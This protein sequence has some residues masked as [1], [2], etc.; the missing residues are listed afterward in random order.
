MEDRIADSEVI[1]KMMIPAS[2]RTSRSSFGTLGL[3][4]MT[5]RP[6]GGGRDR[7]RLVRRRPPQTVLHREAFFL[8]RDDPMAAID[9]EV[10]AANDEDRGAT[11]Q[12]ELFGGMEK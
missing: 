6:L 7:R 11:E 10:D 5:P 3:C 2:D 8:R 12:A 9:E 1:E 4:N